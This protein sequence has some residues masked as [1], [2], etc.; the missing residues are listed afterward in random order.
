[1][2]V[3][4][5]VKISGRGSPALLHQVTVNLLR[6]SYYALKQEAAPGVDRT[7]WK[8]YETG[9]E[10]AAGQSTA[11]RCRHRIFVFADFRII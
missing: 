10:E 1:M 7:T 5:H 6:D 3:G 2:C 9:L 4:Q 11:S 8:E